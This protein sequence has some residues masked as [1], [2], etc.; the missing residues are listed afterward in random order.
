VGEV[1]IVV[2]P[3]IICLSSEDEIFRLFPRNK[4]LSV[5]RDLRTRVIITLLVS[6]ELMVVGIDELTVTT[7]PAATRHE[8]NCHKYCFISYVLT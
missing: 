5:A 3:V 4:A 8:S 1:E 6:Y 2:V 7:L